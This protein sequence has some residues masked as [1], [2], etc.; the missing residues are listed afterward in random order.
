MT[1]LL[2]HLTDD[3]VKLPTSLHLHPSTLHSV[4]LVLDRTLDLLIPATAYPLT[5]TRFTPAFLYKQLDALIPFAISKAIQEYCNTGI[6]LELF[7]QGVV[8]ERIP[9]V[10]VSSFAFHQYLLFTTTKD[11]PLPILYVV[12]LLSGLGHIL[13]QHACTLLQS[14]SRTELS[15]NEL[16]LVLEM[17]VP[18]LAH[19]TGVGK[20]IAELLYQDLCRGGKTRVRSRTIG[21]DETSETTPGREVKT[22]WKKYV[23]DILLP[24][25]NRVAEITQA[26]SDAWE[27][28][29]QQWL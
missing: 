7:N 1:R 19:A 14:S 12:H 26:E 6:A 4:N 16:L 17:E 23:T 27:E 3:I 5:P 2:Y 24:R 13:L 18:G 10:I 25:S 9:E 8:D 21:S 20:L 28:K 29:V 22:W 15:V 11:T